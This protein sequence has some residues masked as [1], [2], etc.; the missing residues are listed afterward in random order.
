MVVRGLL[1]V[2]SFS[3]TLCRVIAADCGERFGQEPFG[4]NDPYIIFLWENGT[5]QPPSADF[6][7]TDR[8]PKG[9]ITSLL[10]LTCFLF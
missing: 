5:F 6:K 10:L 1:A 9:E 3:L 2:F 4:G 8:I 7:N